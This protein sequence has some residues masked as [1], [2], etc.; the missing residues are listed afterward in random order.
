M[1]AMR[2][3]TTERERKV[4]GAN[5]TARRVVEGG[6]R[7]VCLL[8]L[9]WCAGP[10][11]AQEASCIPEGSP[12]AP[13]DPAARLEAARAHAESGRFVE[14]AQ[15]LRGL[16]L[17]APLGEHSVPAAH[18]W[19]DVLSSQSQRAE[20]RLPCLLA[21]EEAAATLHARF[22]GAGG[23]ELCDVL[24][25]MRCEAPLLRAELLVEHAR[26]DEAG[27]LYAEMLASGIDCGRTEEILY[28]AAIVAE[29]AGRP[30]TA[31]RRRQELIARFPSSVVARRALYALASA[32]L[33]LAR[34][35]EAAD[36]YERFASYLPGERC[37]ARV[38][39]R[40]AEL[41]PP[42]DPECADAIDALERAISLRIVLG[43]LAAAE[44]GAAYFE[45]SYTRGHP[46]ETTTALLTVARALERAGRFADARR[47]AERAL[48]ITRS[49]ADDA[50]H[51][52]LIAAQASRALGDA[53]ALEH[54][55]EAAIAFWTEGDGEGSIARAYDGAEEAQRQASARSAVAEAIV[56]RTEARLRDLERRSR[57]PQ[58]GSEWM[59]ARLVDLRAIEEW[60]EMVPAL[61]P[62]WGI[63]AAERIA[64]AEEILSSALRALGANER[65]AEYSARALEH[66]ERCARDAHVLRHYSAEARRC[67]EALTRLDPAH[68][69]DGPFELLGEP[70]IDRELVLPVVRPSP[71]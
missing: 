23:A 30:E 27:Q 71:E 57:T 61:A 40:G 55:L 50:I 46:R 22:C 45:R 56:M 63:A 25:R 17:D 64:N 21:I 33:A 43:D 12:E 48:R 62:E 67:E 65:S 47:A 2:G 70:A 26:Y 44:R 38:V 6:M 10:A 54:H 14:A 32:H 4:G 49:P 7:S 34:Y 69:P 16:A 20:Q 37:Q 9:L 8:L 66:Y 52:H 1:Q 28:N 68:H 15:L 19:L 39:P 35:E 60:L 53:R 31:Q 59:E 58:A 3:G 11:A 29:R 13:A 42:A 18:L 41:D 24:S 5:G 36:A 51:A